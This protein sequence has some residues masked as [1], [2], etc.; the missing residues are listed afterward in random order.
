MNLKSNEKGIRKWLHQSDQ[1]E[2][3]KKK[4]ISCWTI[5]QAKDDF[6]KGKQVW[7]NLKIKILTVL[8]AQKYRFE[9]EKARKLYIQSNWRSRRILLRVGYMLVAMTRHP[10]LKACRRLKRRKTQNIK[11][12]MKT[13][14]PKIRQRKEHYLGLLSRQASWINE[15]RIWFLMLWELIGQISLH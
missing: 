6:Q 13:F 8:K 12:W 3:S 10:R 2:A 1:W 11:E 7:N 5:Q 4:N 15:M 14:N 9:E